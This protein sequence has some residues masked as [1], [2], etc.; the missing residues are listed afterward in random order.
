MRFLL[1]IP[2]SPFHAFLLSMML[3]PPHVFVPHRFETALRL[4]TVTGRFPDTSATRRI[5]PSSHY[6]SERSGRALIPS[7]GAFK[8]VALVERTSDLA[9]MRSRAHKALPFGRSNLLPIVA[10]IG[11]IVRVAFPRTL[12]SVNEPSFRRRIN[13]WRAHL[14]HRHPK[15]NKPN[16]T[17]EQG[18]EKVSN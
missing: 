12:S 10:N 18:Q 15:R 14:L 8:G 5:L 4:D 16:S 11:R 1:Y 7:S 3:P 13:K 2:L 9:C 17:F 6:F